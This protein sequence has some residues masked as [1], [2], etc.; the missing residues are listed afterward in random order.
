VVENLVERFAGEVQMPEARCFYGFQIMMENVHSE[1]YSLLID[2]LINDKDEQA[3]LLNAVETIPC[4]AQKAHWA[5]KWINDK[6][7]S[8]SIRLIAFAVVEGIFFSGAFACIFWLKKRGLMPGLTFSNELISRD[9]GLHTDFAC[10]LFALLNSHPSEA[11]VHKIIQEAVLIEKSFLH[12]ECHHI[13]SCLYT[14]NTFIRCPSSKAYWN[15]SHID[16]TIY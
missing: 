15:E 7:T 11:V 2:T 9:E 8:F 13:P 1:A 12:G 14:I 10:M 5:L 16:V 6:T 3:R 4:I